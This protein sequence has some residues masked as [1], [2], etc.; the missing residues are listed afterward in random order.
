MRGASIMCA[1]LPAKCQLLSL[2][3]YRVNVNSG[4]TVQIVTSDSSSS[5][6][7]RVPYSMIANGNTNQG[8][9]TQRALIAQGSYIAGSHS[10]YYHH[11]PTSS[12]THPLQPLL[13]SFNNFNNGPNYGRQGP[14]AVAK[15]S[16]IPRHAAAQNGR[17]VAYRQGRDV[18]TADLNGNSA[19]FCCRR[20]RSCPLR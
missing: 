12:T 9:S 2:Y 5:V 15:N 14:C 1:N 8:S 4:Y 6:T 10:H 11:H 7:V 16:C 3:S 17:R 18:N 13:I 20:A 19:H